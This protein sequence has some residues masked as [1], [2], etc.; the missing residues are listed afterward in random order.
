MDSFQL[1][2]GPPVNCAMYCYHAEL[3]TPQLR[4]IAARHLCMVPPYSECTVNQQGC[5]KELGT[6][7]NRGRQG[8]Q[9][10]PPRR[11]HALWPLARSMN[12]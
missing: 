7:L 12:A 6:S 9:A 10:L 5:Q 11:P 2:P 1:K 3:C 4:S 8:W